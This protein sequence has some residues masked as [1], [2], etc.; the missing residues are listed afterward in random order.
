MSVTEEAI[1]KA[2]GRF[3]APME[4]WGCTN[5]PRYNT[6]RF[7][8]YRNC[9]HKMD[10]YVVEHAKRSIQEYAQLNSSMGGGRGSQVIQYGIGQT[11]LNH[12]VFHV[13]RSQKLYIPIVE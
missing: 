6:D 5:S 7:R 9:P 1:R 2:I 12:N 13:R 3:N 4:C 10:P 11:I 8:V